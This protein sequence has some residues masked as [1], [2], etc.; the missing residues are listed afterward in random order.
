MA[1]NG[2]DGAA[3]P[4]KI[5]KKPSAWRGILAAVIVLCGAA[6]AYIAFLGPATVG[7]QRV[8]GGEKTAKIAEVEPELS[9]TSVP[10][11]PEEPKV[12]P[13]ARP[14]KV[15]EV[16]NGYVMLPSG[17]I[18]KPTGVV[19]NRVADYGR[20]KYSI[21]EKRSDNE[22]AAILMM[23]PGD[24]LV[25]TKRYDKWFTKQFLESLEEPIEI[26]DDDEPWQA[27]LKRSV[28]EARKEL[29]AAYD[30]GEDI[31][32]MMAESRQQLQDLSQYKQ[33]IRQLYAQNLQECESDEH[34]EELQK[35][36]NVMLEE[37]GCAPIDFTPLTK[38]NLK[39]GEE[40]E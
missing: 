14:T 30:N 16:V 13:S 31:D 19:T 34:L 10:E 1:W 33:Q 18:H 20:S 9:V 17:R 2:S 5:E 22:I 35:A 8:K 25:G 26:S 12:D 40:D 23:K 37:K 4:R 3:K 15:G 24:T 7:G 39:K 27:E 29:K 11:K 6:V 38:M 32:E 28:I 21:F 36:V